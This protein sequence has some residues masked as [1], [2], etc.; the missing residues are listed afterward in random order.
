MRIYKWA[1]EVVDQQTLALPAGAQILCVQV[2][3]ERPCIWALVD[4]SAG[5]EPR[6]LLMYGTGHPV[7]DQAGRYIGTYQLDRGG[8]VFHV[9]EAK[10]AQ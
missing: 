7:S 2:Q 6:A 8:L 5:L 3:Y 9:F 1:L 4:P 10:K